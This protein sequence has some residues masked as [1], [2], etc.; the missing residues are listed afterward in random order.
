MVLQ[1]EQLLESVS[2]RGSADPMRLTIGD[3]CFLS[4]AETSEAFSPHPIEGTC[5][6]A[7]RACCM[8]G[9]SLLA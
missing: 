4:N 7:S 5:L 8:C 3:Q 1:K 2:K 6:I 9:I